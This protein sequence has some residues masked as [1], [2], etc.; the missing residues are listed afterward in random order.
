M[1]Q[2]LRDALIFTIALLVL[3]AATAGALQIAD[4]R[5]HQKPTKTPAVLASVAPAP[6]NGP[7]IA[8][9]PFTGF[10]HHSDGANGARGSPAPRPVTTTRVS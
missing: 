5:D 4:V 9:A 1:S 10:H 6:R 7:L 8:P 2:R 3:V